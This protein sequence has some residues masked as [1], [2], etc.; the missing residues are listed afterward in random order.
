MKKG[1]HNAHSTK[2]IVTIYYP[3][4]PLKGKCYPLIGFKS[5]NSE[6][7]MILLK[8]SGRYLYIPDWMTDHKY[9]KI[10]ITFKPVIEYKTLKSLKRMIDTFL[11]VLHYKNKNI[12]SEET[13][14]IKQDQTT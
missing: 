11:D 8:S 7:F 10:K 3:Y 6:K 5:N 9:A 13:N 4:H 1:L 2:K 14:E 12:H